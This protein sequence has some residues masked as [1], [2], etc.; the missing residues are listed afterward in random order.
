MIVLVTGWFRKYDRNGQPTGEKEFC[1]SHGVDMDTGETI[2]TSC[3]HPKVLGAVWDE[4]MME[5]VIE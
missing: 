3:D 2:I 4:V 1:T 5:W